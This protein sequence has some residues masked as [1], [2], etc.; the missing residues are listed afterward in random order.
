MAV[1]LAIA[2]GV[3]GALASGIGTGG[4][5]YRNGSSLSRRFWGYGDRIRI[6]E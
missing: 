6:A 4:G 5:A 1:P 2:G 3:A